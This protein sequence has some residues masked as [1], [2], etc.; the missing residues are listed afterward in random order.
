MLD[1]FNV[2]FRDYIL[3]QSFDI[4]NMFWYIISKYIILIMMTNKKN[5]TVMIK[6]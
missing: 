6:D 2:N 3:G 4:E 1:A 5:L